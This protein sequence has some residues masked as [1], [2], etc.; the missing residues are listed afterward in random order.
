[1]FSSI[2]RPLPATSAES[3]RI[4]QRI[5]SDSLLRVRALSTGV[6]SDPLLCAAVLREANS[7]ASSPLA[8]AHYFCPVACLMESLETA[9]PVDIDMDTWR[10]PVE[11]G[12]LRAR[13]IL[14]QH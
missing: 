9:P 10:E 4:A 5:L 8:I 14:F 12:V 2:R 6:R 3:M 1:M 11:R 7:A 13:E